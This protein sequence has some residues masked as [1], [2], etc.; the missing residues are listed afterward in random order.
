MELAL[1]ETTLTAS[2]DK[3]ATYR[4]G[5]FH[6]SKLPPCTFGGLIVFVVV[7]FFFVVVVYCLWFI[8]LVLLL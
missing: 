7:L 5:H 8:G 3:T 4:W 2:K 1:G 6:S